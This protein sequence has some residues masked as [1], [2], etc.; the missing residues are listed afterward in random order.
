MSNFNPQS[1]D[2]NFA[3]IFERMDNQDKVLADIRDQTTKTN[4]RV[5]ALE[6][7]KGQIYIIV[8]V[9][10]SLLTLYATWRIK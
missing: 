8:V 10:F 4:G 5:T 2:S 7:F 3:K 9:T 6:G 1:S